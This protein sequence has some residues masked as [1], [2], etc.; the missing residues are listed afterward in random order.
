MKLPPVQPRSR[1][2]HEAAHWARAVDCFN[3]YNLAIFRAFFENGENIGKVDVLVRLASELGLDGQALR[4]SLERRDHEKSFLA[5][6]QDAQRYGVRSVPA[7]VVG[8]QVF[9]S[10]VQPLDRLKDLVARARKNDCV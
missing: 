8:G 9:L 2:A 7:F 1:M 3:D 10:G 5:E 4:A 6:T